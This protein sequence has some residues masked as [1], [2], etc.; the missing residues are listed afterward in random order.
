MYFCRSYEETK[1]LQSFY[2]RKRLCELSTK[3]VKVFSTEKEV[4]ERNQEN[5]VNKFLSVSLFGF[6]Q[7]DKIQLQAGEN[8][9]EQ[10]TKSLAAKPQ[11]KPWI[12]KLSL[13]FV[14]VYIIFSFNVICSLHITFFSFI[15]ICFF[16][17][18]LFYVFPHTH[19]QTHIFRF[20]ISL[21]WFFV[22]VQ[23]FRLF[24]FGCFFG[25]IGGSSKWTRWKWR[26]NRVQVHK[27]LVS[28]EK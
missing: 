12:K 27:E 19:K 17:S 13:Q 25:N 18:F 11:T 16:S 14:G 4:R 3:S 8:K 21:V 15:F 22:I 28:L 2:R 24:F 6:K 1:R 10:V 9:I 26:V 7:I 23:I 20:H 5:A